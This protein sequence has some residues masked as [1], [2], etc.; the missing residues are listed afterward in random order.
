M[1]IGVIV[2]MLAM[3]VPLCLLYEGVVIFARI[4]DRRK[5]RR[6]LSA[7]YSQYADDETS[8]IT[9]DDLDQQPEV[10]VGGPGKSGGDTRYDSDIT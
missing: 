7:E 10:S 4:H 1:V 5:E 2:L 6:S 3:A 9:M 8:P